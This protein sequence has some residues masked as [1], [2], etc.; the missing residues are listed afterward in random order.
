MHLKCIICQ[1][2]CYLTLEKR[3]MGLLRRVCVKEVLR[4]CSI[5]DDNNNIDDDDN[6]VVVRFVMEEGHDHKGYKIVEHSGDDVIVGESSEGGE[7]KGLVHGVSFTS[8]NNY[9]KRDGLLLIKKKKDFD[10]LITRLHVYYF[11][12]INKKGGFWGVEIDSIRMKLKVN[13]L[14]TRYSPLYDDM[15][16]FHRCLRWKPAAF[17]EHDQLSCIYLFPFPYS[18]SQPLSYSNYNK[19]PHSGS[20]NVDMINYDR[21]IYPQYPLPYSYNNSGTQNLNGLASSSG[22]TTGNLNHS[23]FQQYITFVN[24]SFL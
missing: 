17:P 10:G 15:M 8:N 4:T 3:R 21:N 13:N 20:N 1:R 2:A 18:Y 11:Y 24:P 16:L 23:V 14:D 19:L 7:L 5:G 12:L 6:V 22:Y 9:S